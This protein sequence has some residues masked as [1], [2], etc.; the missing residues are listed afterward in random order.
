MTIKVTN[1]DWRTKPITIKNK[2]VRTLSNGTVIP[3]ALAMER[4]ASKI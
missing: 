2:T 3:T 4:K 1:T